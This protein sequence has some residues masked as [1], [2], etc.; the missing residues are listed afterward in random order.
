MTP[1][2]A[3]GCG[4]ADALATAEGTADDEAASLVATG[5][6]TAAASLAAGVTAACAGACAGVLDGPAGTAAAAPAAGMRRS[7]VRSSDAACP[8]S[9]RCCWYSC[10]MRAAS[11]G[12]A[13]SARGIG[14]SVGGAHEAWSLNA[15]APG[16]CVCSDT[17]SGNTRSYGAT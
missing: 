14:D 17:S 2:A 9:S 10:W 11:L 6:A 15:Y 4:A 7:G 12:H 8:S 16:T 3:D 1:G 13:P 5:W